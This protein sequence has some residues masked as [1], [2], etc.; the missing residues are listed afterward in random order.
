MHGFHG[1]KI[2]QTIL[3][4][5]LTLETKTIMLGSF[6]GYITEKLYEAEISTSQ[7]CNQV[8]HVK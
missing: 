6:P 7:L 1:A 4:T 5:F 3:E 2:C 8:I